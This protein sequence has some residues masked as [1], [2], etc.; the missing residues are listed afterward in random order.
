MKR[1]LILLIM[2]LP[3]V[4]SGPITCA[5]CTASATTACAVAYTTFFPTAP[6][7][8]SAGFKL[9]VALCVSPTP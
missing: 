6:F 4:Y 5:G 1:E 8:C 9:C 2:L 3:I 7:V